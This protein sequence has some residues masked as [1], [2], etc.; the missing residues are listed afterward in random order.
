[1]CR[2]TWAI[3]LD[4]SSLPTIAAKTLS[5][6][7]QASISSGSPSIEPLIIPMS[8]LPF[9]CAHFL[10]GDWTTG[11][12]QI[13]DIE[14]APH[15]ILVHTQGLWVC[16]TYPS[17]FPIFI[18]CTKLVNSVVYMQGNW[19]SVYTVKLWKSVL[20]H[21]LYV[22]LVTI[23]NKWTETVNHKNI[24]V[25]NGAHK[26]E[27]CWLTWIL[28]TPS[29]LDYFRWHRE[30]WLRPFW[31]LMRYNV[32]LS[33]GKVIQFTWRDRGAVALHV[34]VSAM[35]THAASS[36]GQSSAPSYRYWLL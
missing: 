33:Y 7:L 25:A 12:E 35:R 20:T 10:C 36:P 3:W 8:L 11:E 24:H 6:P 14:A 28:W 29:H 23:I 30:K 9:Q 22:L 4:W 19:Y 17:I 15:Q 2:P 18:V 32:I 26:T 1:M 16:L 27:T 34:A 5:F 31:V 21:K 13:F